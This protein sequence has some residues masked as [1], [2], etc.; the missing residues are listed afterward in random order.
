M[1][2]NGT[3]LVRNAA[4]RRGAARPNAATPSPRVSAIKSV[5]PE[6]R[7]YADANTD[8]S[9]EGSSSKR[10]RDTHATRRSSISAHSASKVDLP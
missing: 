1:S 3:G 10:S 2:T 7:A 4:A 9:A 5:W 8:S 6:I